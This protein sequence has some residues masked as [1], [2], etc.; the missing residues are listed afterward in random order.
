MTVLTILFLALAPAHSQTRGCL[1]PP[2]FP[3]PD[4]RI[5]DFSADKVSI[6]PGESVVLTWA[7]ENPGPMTVAPGVGPVV[8]RG[9]ARVSPSATTTYTLSVAGGPGGEVLK[10]ALTVT[11]AGTTPIAAGASDASARGWPSAS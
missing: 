2:Q 7:A 10:R 8:A 1:L 3:C 9:T 6:K 11:V 5:M 4:A